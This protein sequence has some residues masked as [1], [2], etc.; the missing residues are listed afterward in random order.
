MGAS[1]S[2]FRYRRAIQKSRGSKVRRAEGTME[3][4]PEATAVPA[5]TTGSS[6]N[7]T[8]T[9]PSTTSTIASVM[10]TTSQTT[11]TAPT[12]CTNT[13]SSSSS[14]NSSVSSTSTS[15]TSSTTTTTATGR[16]AVP[17]ISVYS[18]MPDRQTVQV[19]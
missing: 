17:Q 7:T 5:N 3:S 11:T 1:F 13:S 9:F 2:V 19:S 4:A 12:T 16:L 14:N 18:G 15:S 8:T 10:S 6:V